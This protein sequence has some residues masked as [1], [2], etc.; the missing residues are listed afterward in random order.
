MVAEVRAGQAQGIELSQRMREDF[1]NLAPR[2][3]LETWSAG[4]RGLC[5]LFA[6]SDP[7]ARMPWFG[8][9]MSVVSFVAA[10][11]ME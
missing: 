3:L 11:Q 9:D 7:E 6:A 4:W 2:E 5:E 1:G 10:R 8:P